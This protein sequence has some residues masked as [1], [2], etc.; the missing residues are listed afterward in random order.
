MCTVAG[1][2][3]RVASECAICRNWAKTGLSAD[4]VAKLH[5]VRLQAADLGESYLGAAFPDDNMIVVDDDAGGWGWL[6]ELAP[7]DDMQSAQPS[8]QLEEGSVNLLTAVMHEF[9][10]ILGHEHEDSGLIA[11][12][13]HSNLRFE[14]GDDTRILIVDPQ[15]VHL[16][17]GTL[18]AS[19]G[20]DLFETLLA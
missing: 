20:V 13:L 2:Q 11:D 17:I 7:Q 10:H 15:A 4:Q 14:P 3:V 5:A 19:D 1:R 6:R 16:L 18:V 12:T 9:G 8:D